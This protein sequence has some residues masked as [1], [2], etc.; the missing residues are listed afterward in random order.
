MPAKVGG[1]RIGYAVFPQ[2]GIVEQTS[3]GLDMLIHEERSI[4]NQIDADYVERIGFPFIIAVKGLQKSD[5]LAAFKSRIQN[6]R[7]TELATAY[8]QVEKIASLRLKEML[9]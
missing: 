1:N 2:S 9:K 5:I 8:S 6:D 3:A 7:R 4:F